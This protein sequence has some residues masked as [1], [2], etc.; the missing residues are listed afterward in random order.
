MPSL[1]EVDV[2][3]NAIKW[4]VLIRVFSLYGLIFSLSILFY[5]RF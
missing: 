1:R 2:E 4:D 3:M 5:F